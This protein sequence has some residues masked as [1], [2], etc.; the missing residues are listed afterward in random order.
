MQDI[1]SKWFICV[2]NS[3]H[4]QWL[5]LECGVAGRAKYVTNKGTTDAQRSSSFFSFYSNLGFEN[6]YYQVDGDP[7]GT[8]LASTFQL[9][10]GTILPFAIIITSNII[11]ITTV[12][13]A[14]RKRLGLQNKMAERDSGRRSSET[15]YLTRMLVLVSVAYVATSI[16]YRLYFIILLIPQVSE[17]FDL[18]DTC[19]FILYNVMAFSLH[20]LWVWNYAIN[21]YMYCA[22]GGRRYRDDIK[23]VLGDWKKQCCF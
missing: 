15:E 23:Y 16:P 9:I 5:C 12:R 2:T 14:A 20:G 11:I 8:L 6:L 21:F 13:T 19:Y 7:I 18:S 4:Y 3:N 10:F 1:N 22:G 17:K